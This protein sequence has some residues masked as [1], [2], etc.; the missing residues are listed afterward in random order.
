MMEEEAEER[1]NSVKRTEREKIENVKSRNR[2]RTNRGR[3]ET[4]K[5]S[6]Q[7]KWKKGQRHKRTRWIDICG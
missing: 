1:V 5:S 6:D 4:R 3:G 2:A 7:E